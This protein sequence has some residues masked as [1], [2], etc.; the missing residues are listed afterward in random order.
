METKRTEVGE[1]GEFG[2]IARL[3]KN[4]TNKNS[5]TLKAV[6][7]DA[8]VI[9]GDEKAK[10]V[11][12]DLLVEGVH[13][14]MAYTP[15][16]HLGYKAVAVNLSDV[17][18]M[19][20]HPKQI[21]VSLAISNRFSVEALEEIYAGVQLACE[22][23]GVD[24]I[25][26]DTTSSSSGLM[27]SVTAIGEAYEEQIAY[28]NGAEVGD[29][30]CVSGDLGA[31]YVG[32]I[33][34]EREKQVWLEHPDVQP[35]LENEN[36]L[37]G[38]LLKPE[39]RKEVIDILAKRDIQPKAMIDVSDGLSSDLKHICTAS[40]V[41]ALIMEEYVPI[42]KET[43]DKALKFNTDP[44]TTALN[45]GEDYEL[46]FTIKKEDES[47]LETITGITVIGEVLTVEEGIKIKTKAGN[48][49]DLLAMG[50]DGLQNKSE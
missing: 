13:F 12:T 7:D 27:I 31:A 19:N 39:P 37:V 40:N 28:R 20:A 25:G 41:G 16:R 10:V 30:I 43:Y 29:I 3:T 26:G 34:L 49:H 45:G 35:D 9:K 42:A 44:I 23:Y 6:G 21:T 48:I 2:L 18:A 5:S 15:L 17:Y 11:T 47:K 38:R 22:R 1:I 4:F 33:L 46:L 32:L 36:Y 14:D 24:L 50:W 8:A